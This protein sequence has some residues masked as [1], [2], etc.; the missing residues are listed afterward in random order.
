MW[1]KQA[2]EFEDDSNPIVAVKGAKVSDFNGKSISCLSSSAML[3]NPDIPEA[4]EL[5]GWYDNEGCNVESF[6]LS[7]ARTGGGIV[8]WLIYILCMC[9]IFNYYFLITIDRGWNSM[10]ITS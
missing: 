4:H 7:V 1:G 5:R 8:N 9:C 10:E 2:E 3:F 6:S